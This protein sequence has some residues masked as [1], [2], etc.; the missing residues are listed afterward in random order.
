MLIEFLL[1][2]EGTK[3]IQNA[4]EIMEFVEVQRRCA[5]SYTK[6]LSN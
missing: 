5:Q 4:A 3:L 1:V 6:I 2:V